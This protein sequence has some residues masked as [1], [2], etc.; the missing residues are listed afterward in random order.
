MGILGG[1]S[2]IQDI[3]VHILFSNLGGQQG[4][5]RV[6]GEG[7]GAGV[8]SLPHLPLLGEG[9]QALLYA[10]RGESAQSHRETNPS[11]PLGC[12]VTAE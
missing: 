10:R 3:R 12:Q 5:K 1:L 6:W 7:S 8:L 4:R 2:E 11:G 9:S